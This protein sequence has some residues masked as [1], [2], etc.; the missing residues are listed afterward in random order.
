MFRYRNVVA[1]M[2]PDGN[3]QTRI[4]QTEKSR[5]PQ[6]VMRLDVGGVQQCINTP[7][8]DSF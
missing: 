5:T 4:G 2:S 1:E 8:L 7:S 6:G 3:G